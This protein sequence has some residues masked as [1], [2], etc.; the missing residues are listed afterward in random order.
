DLSWLGT[1]L[2]R[3]EAIRLMA[4]ARPTAKLRQTFHYQNNMYSAAG[5]IVG[6]ANGS[7]WE[8]V[9]IDR[10]LKPLGMASTV[11]SM[12]G[13]R[14]AADIATGHSLANAKAQAAALVD[15][16]NMAAAGAIASNGRDMAQWLRLMLAAGEFDG[17][18]LVSERAF[19]EMTKSHIAFGK[20]GYG[21]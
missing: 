4:I 14:Q 16:D 13:M 3:E 9:V 11:G 5:E 10:L 19:A 21:L 7:T 12:T 17:R 2:T 18:R 20:G 8:Q 6:R 15:M 1:P